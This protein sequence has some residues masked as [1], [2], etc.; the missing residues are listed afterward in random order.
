L[1]NDGQYEL[2]LPE[3][4]YELYATARAHSRSPEKAVTLAA[5]EEATQH[6]SWLQAPGKMRLTVSDQD[7]PV[8]ARVT[9]EEGETPL[10]GFLGRS[11]F[12]TPATGDIG[13]AAFE[14]APGDY[15]FGI[16][17]GAGFV[18][19]VQTTDTVTVP[20][21]GSAS[22][23]VTVR[24]QARPGEQGWYSADLHHHG[25]G[26][27]GVTPPEYVFRSEMA[28]RLDL[29]FL[30]D[31]DTMEYLP[32]VAELAEARGVP[33]I[34]SIEISPSWGHFNPY[35]VEIGRELS[36]TPGTASVDEI[37]QEARDLGASVVQAN[38]PSNPYG[39][40]SSL[41]SNTVPGGFNP[42]FDAMGLNACCYEDTWKQAQTY[43]N[44][45]LA[46]DLERFYP[47]TAGS[48]T[49][50]VWNEISGRLRLYA[51]V[52]KKLTVDSFLSAAEA[53]HSYAT[54][55]PL[56]FP[57]N[58]GG[59]DEAV[60]F[61]KT[62]SVASG[63]SFDFAVDLQAVRSLASVTLIRA[64]EK[65]ESRDLSGGTTAEN[66]SFSVEP[67]QKTWYALVV[68]DGDENR[69]YTN[70]IRVEPR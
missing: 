42:G 43:W 48:D 30:S 2:S 21:T 14:I 24:T 52:D 26:A 25:L 62:Y 59:S 37:F 64:G 60:L 8:D 4:D 36:I 35:P 6:F 10:I 18:S 66:V 70:P 20:P 39:Y 33:F 38:H 54:F 46:G 13:A 49:H 16:N 58:A 51:H 3:G 7:G 41:D 61:G 44:R 17:S 69:A 27:E 31:H 28:A 56:I 29:A 57:Q 50:D 12:F 34:P 11:T 19:S 53:G 23:E 9:I 15:R 65:V 63:E 32:A 47:L 5:D 22:R 55:G 67:K 68:A 1:G 40:F 45:A